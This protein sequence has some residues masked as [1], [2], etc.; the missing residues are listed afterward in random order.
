MSALGA[1]AVRAARARSNGDLWHETAV[2]ADE[3]V[4]HATAV[5]EAMPEPQRWVMAEMVGGLIAAQA[6]AWHDEADPTVDSVHHP[7]LTT[8][9]VG[10]TELRER[11]HAMVVEDR[12]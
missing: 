9:M 10:V 5:L 8:S 6:H 4:A 3:L 12:A 11:L 7:R 2:A 1:A